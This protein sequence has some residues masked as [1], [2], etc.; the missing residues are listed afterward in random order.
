M[1][2]LRSLLP[3]LLFFPGIYTHVAGDFVTDHGAKLIGWGIE[4]GR[5]YWLLV[6]S[7]GVLWGERGLFKVAMDGTDNSDFGFV[8]VGPTFQ[9]NSGNITL[10]CLFLICLMQMLANFRK[11]SIL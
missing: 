11:S 8:I 5:S 10:C 1:T 2:L 6:N 9:K 4:N 7:F 3:K